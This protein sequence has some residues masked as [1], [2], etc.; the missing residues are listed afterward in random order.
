M[1]F[2]LAILYQ[3]TTGKP[4]RIATIANPE[5]LAKA[6]AAAID[7]AH[8]RADRL[9][10]VD[11]ELSRIER[12]EADRLRQILCGILAPCSSAAAA[13]VM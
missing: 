6:A 3:P 11:D 5:L 13:S 2:S 4:L 12:T 10:V 9:A 8:F 1:R 7:E